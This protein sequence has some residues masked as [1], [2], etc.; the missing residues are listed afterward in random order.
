MQADI[1]SWDDNAKQWSEFIQQDRKAGTNF[2]EELTQDVLNKL[3]GNVEDK[4]IFVPGCG[5]GTYANN[6]SRLGGAIVGADGSENMLKIA[7]KNYPH[8]EF[9]IMDMLDKQNF[10]DRSFDFVVANML[11]MSLSDINTFLGESARILGSK[12]KLILSVL[13]PCFAYPTMKLYKTFMQKIFF[14]KPRGLVFNYF[15]TGRSD[16]HEDNTFIKVP[17]Y[18]RTLEDYSHAL[19]QAGF[20]IEEMLEPHELSEEILKNHP[21]LEYITRLPRFLFFKASLR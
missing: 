14:H 15:S 17:F 10:P 12:G 20:V 19:K 9:R 8:I 21:K 7:R 6:L 13:H 2:R 11:L 16:R 4:R 5:E 18:H 1:K 3:L